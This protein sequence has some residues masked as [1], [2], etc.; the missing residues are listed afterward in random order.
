M[1]PTKY[2]LVIYLKTA[3]RLGSHSAFIGF[4]ASAAVWPVMVRVHQQAM[5]VV[6]YIGT[7]SRE[8]NA[9]R[10]PSLHQGLREPIHYSILGRI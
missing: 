3:K 2:E 4:V 7:G 9:F 10:L 1:Q 8:S 6:R 5:P